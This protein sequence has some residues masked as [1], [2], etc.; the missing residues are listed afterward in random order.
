[1]GTRDMTQLLTGAP[2]WVWPL[3]VVLMLVGLRARKERTAPVLLIYGLPALGILGLRSVAALPAE[4]WIWALF[5]VG[6][7]VGCWGGYLVQRRW[8][9]GREGRMV[10]LA[11]EGLTLGVMM[12]MFWANFAGGVLQAVAPQLYS[13]SLFQV[14]FV[15]VI[16]CAGGSFAGRALRVWRA[17][18]SWEA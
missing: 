18:V 6:Y 14:I 10:Q 4:T 5:A 11:G 7:G 15:G 2:I 17:P 8:V 1:M 16:A 9:L 3:L 12:I 13:S